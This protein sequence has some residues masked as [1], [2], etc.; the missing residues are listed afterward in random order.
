MEVEKFSSP[1]SE[2][3]Q[4]Q[5]ME[6]DT[7]S[8]YSSVPQENSYHSDHEVRSTRTPEVR[9][10]PTDGENLESTLLTSHSSPPK[11]NRPRCSSL[12]TKTRFQDYVADEQ[13]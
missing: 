11:A 8:R 9:R 7:E 3:L 13:L 12:N 2:G 10:D 1:K 4:S 5:Q 6:T